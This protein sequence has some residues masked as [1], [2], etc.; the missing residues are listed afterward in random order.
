[1]GNRHR[2]CQLIKSADPRGY[3]NLD[4][5]RQAFARLD[6][7]RSRWNEVQPTEVEG[8]RRQRLIK[9]TR[10]RMGAGDR[11]DGCISLTDLPAEVPR[12]STLG[13]MGRP[14]G[15]GAE[16]HES[17]GRGEDRRGPRAA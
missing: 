11:T 4:E 7:M 3:V 14:A 13:H 15:T 9:A 6:Y 12:A 17:E 8:R 2:G 16:Q 1:M 10:R 5:A